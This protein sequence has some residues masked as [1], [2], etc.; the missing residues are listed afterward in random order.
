MTFVSSKEEKMKDKILIIGGYGK[1]GRVISTHLASRYPQQVIVAGRNFKKAQEVAQEL[2]STVIPYTLDIHTAVDDP[3]LEQ[4]QL[5]IMCIDQQDTSFVASCIKHKVHYMDITANQVFMDQVEALHDQAMQNQ[6][7][8]ALSIGL[9]PGITNLLTKHGLNQVPKATVADLFVLLGLGEKHGDAA[10]KWTFDNIHTTYSLMEKEKTVQIKSFTQP[11]KTDVLGKRSF[12]TFNFSDQHALRRTTA[13][14]TV[15]TRMAF[16]SKVI[17]SLVG[18][19]R[20]LGITKVFTLP[21]VQN[22]SMILFKSIGLGSDVFGVKVVVSNPENERYE[23]R[24]TGHDEGK[25]TA[26]VAIEMALYLLQNK[27]PF[28]VNHM[29]QVIEDIPSFLAKLKVHNSTIQFDL[30]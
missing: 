11:L 25:T 15:K 18:F 10:Y 29:H 5:V 14:T 17:T 3:I 7:L 26:A 23:C 13:L 30:K 27:V 12:Y 19:L 8:L 9:A 21:K 16:D 28:G 4:T 22:L 20:K 6:V 24:V 2:H 1:V